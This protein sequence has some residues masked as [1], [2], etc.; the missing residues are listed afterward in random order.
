MG[1]IVGGFMNVGMRN[2]I[3]L[4]RGRVDWNKFVTVIVLSVVE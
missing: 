2:Y 4:F 1:F 3:V